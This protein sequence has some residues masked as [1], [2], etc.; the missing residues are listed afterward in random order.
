[1]AQSAI[2]D[3]LKHLYEERE[4]LELEAQNKNLA[5]LIF[6]EKQRNDLLSM[7][8]LDHLRIEVIEFV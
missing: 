1:M 2:E 3:A 6:A 5:K 4:Y 7:N 8:I